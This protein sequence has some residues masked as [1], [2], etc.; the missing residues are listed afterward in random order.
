MNSYK[1]NALLLADARRSLLGH[2]PVAV[3]SF[4]LY[5]AFELFLNS[6]SQSFTFDNAFLTLVVLLVVQ[7]VTGLF[8]S[9]FSVGLSAVFLNL[10]YGMDA[11][12]SDL[13]ICF[14]DNQDTSIRVRSLVTAGEVLSLLPLQLL[15]F[16]LPKGELTSYLPLVI[17]AVVMSLA[18]LLVWRISF[19]MTNFLLLD[20]P[21]LGA[22]R[23][24]HT[25]RSMM[26]GNRLRYFFLM[27]RI[28]PLHLLDFLSFGFSVL[29]TGSYQRA[30]MAAFYKDMI[31]T[32]AES[33]S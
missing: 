28:L 10:Q 20:F 12:V 25:A 5:T 16:F 4:L 13:F 33:A 19:A 9:L 8:A 26:R 11:R 24:L 1:S 32:A 30:A 15:L 22:G 29:W 23:I 2:L 17:L 7:F 18:A 3:W 14:R 6:L 27:L 21:E 31:T